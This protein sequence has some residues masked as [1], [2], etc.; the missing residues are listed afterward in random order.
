MYIICPNCKTNFVVESYVLNIK[1]RK[2]KCSKCQHVWHQKPVHFDAASQEIL[3]QTVQRRYHVPAIIQQKKIS[4]LAIS[5]IM[6]SILYLSFLGLMR[7]KTWQN[8]LYRQG[9]HLEI[10]K[11]EY[12]DDQLL[13]EYRILQQGDF[14]NP[15]PNIKISLLGDKRQVVAATSF[16]AIAL[17]PYRYLYIKTKFESLAAQINIL[18]I[19]LLN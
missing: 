5:V 9:L 11:L 14:S 3:P 2:V 4:W 18:E 7:Y 15:A 12:L 19:V 17:S 6:L 8:N 16:K 13:L 10:I 1:G